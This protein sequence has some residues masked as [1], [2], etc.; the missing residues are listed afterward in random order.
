MQGY[1]NKS[2]IDIVKSYL[3]NERPFIQT[4]YVGNKLKP[5]AEGEVWKDN[6]GV[7]WKQEKGYQVRVNK[8]ADI[9]RAALKE[10]CKTCGQIIKWGTKV[11]KIFF[12]KTGMCSNCVIDYE[13][14]LRILNIYDEY[15]KYKLLSNHLGGLNEVKN[16]LNDALGAFT[17]GGGDMEMICNSE[18]FIERWKTNDKDQIAND[19][20]EDLKKLELAIKN[21][22]KEVKIAKEAYVTSTKKYKIDAYV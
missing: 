14:K 18:G 17:N 21:T 13:T 10:K 5:R 7:T 15:E 12:N 19:I 20:R 9:I 8:Q 16:Q 4:G 11:D 22:K 1:K 3:N 2:N 6:R